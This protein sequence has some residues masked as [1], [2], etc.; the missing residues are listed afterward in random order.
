MIAGSRPSPEKGGRYETSPPTISASGSGRCR[1]ADG[2]ALREGASL[3]VAAGA[4]DCPFAPGGTT[5][6]L[7]RLIGQWLSERLGQPFIVENR[8]GAATMIGTEAVVRAP[9]DGYTLM[10]C[11]YGE[12]DQRDALREQA[13]VQFSPRHRAGCGHSP[14]AQRRGG[15]SVG[16]GQD[17]SRVHR[18]R[19]GQSGQ[20]Q[21]GIGSGTGSAAII[22]G[23]LFKVMTGVDFV[24]VPYRGKAPALT[25]LLAGQVQLDFDTM[26]SSIEYI[27]AGKLRALAV[28]TASRVRRHCRTSRA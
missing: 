17:G 22:A 10:V 20:D 15:E 13:Q 2:V 16:S 3:S 24:H 28:T 8:P 1:A 4:R 9:A 6:I 25:D 12:R 19:Q 27:R 21:H 23:E 18:L 7:A 5:D 11:R 26:P 14:R